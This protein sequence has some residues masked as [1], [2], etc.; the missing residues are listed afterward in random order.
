MPNATPGGRGQALTAPAPR[1]SA[2][3]AAPRAHGATNRKRASPAW[4]SCSMAFVRNRRVVSHAFDT[5]RLVDFKRGA[6]PAHLLRCLRRTRRQSSHDCGSFGSC[7]WAERVSSNC[8]PAASPILPL[9]RRQGE[10]AVRPASRDRGARI[11][12][13]EVRCHLDVEG[14]ILLGQRFSKRRRRNPRILH[15]HAPLGPAAF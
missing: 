10:A 3:A 1:R 8:G 4:K 2:A 11:N 9:L 7:S 13:Y 5:R 12:D 14:Q 15:R 6:S